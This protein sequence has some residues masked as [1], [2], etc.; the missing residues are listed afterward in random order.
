[1][2]VELTHAAKLFT[3]ANFRRHAQTRRLGPKPLHWILRFCS[4]DEPSGD[5]T[6]HLPPGWT[7]AVTESET[8]V[9]NDD[10]RSHHELASIHEIADRA[11]MLDQGKVIAYGPWIKLNRLTIL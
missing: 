8:P 9:S 11:I 10:C 2:L 6:P 5:W 1:M 3:P 7:E 4:Q